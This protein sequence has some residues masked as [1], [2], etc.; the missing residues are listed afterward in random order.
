MHFVP[1]NISPR[2]PFEDSSVTVR[3][4]ISLEAHT[5]LHI[6]N[7]GLLG[8]KRMWATS[9]GEGSTFKK[10]VVS[11]ETTEIANKERTSRN[12]ESMREG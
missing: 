3:A 6:L 4:V 2:V 12:V 9:F 1:C 5:E 10:V 8:Q 7:R 11:C